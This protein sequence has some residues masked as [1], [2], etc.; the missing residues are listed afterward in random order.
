VAKSRNFI[1]LNGRRYDAITGQLWR[2]AGTNKIITR[3]IET[4]TPGKVINDVVGPK[5]GTSLLQYEK[6]KINH[7]LPSK[8]KSI[9]KPVQPEVAFSPISVSRSVHQ[10][11]AHPPEKTKTL[12]RAG[13]HKPGPSNSKA[14]VHVRSPIDS[15]FDSVK[16][17]TTKLPKRID[18]LRLSKARTIEPSH[19]VSHFNPDKITEN[20]KPTITSLPVHKP[21]TTTSSG[22]KPRAIDAVYHANPYQRHLEKVMQQAHSHEQPPVVLKRHG[23]KKHRWLTI[24]IISLVVLS[25]GGVLLTKNLSVIE[26]DLASTHAGF[27]AK[28]PSYQPAG[29]SLIDHLQASYDQVVLLYH[30]RT[31]GRNYSV[32][33]QIS[34]WDSQTLQ[35]YIDSTG[36][37]VQSWQNRGITLYKYGNQLT[38][39]S[40]ETWYQITNHASLS[41]QQMLAIAES[42]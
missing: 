41:N 6:T 2:D 28:L 9:V 11:K 30:T 27:K 1:E 12:S 42:F 21:R 18:P 38:W 23:H 8:V 25:A 31:D 13:V 5:A 35:N 10:L 20:H 14:L 17:K 3:S 15:A 40:G 39:V 29:F 33:Q 37:S 36:K 22:A 19:M 34:N 26:I 24:L 7:Q 32:S 16:L 4:T